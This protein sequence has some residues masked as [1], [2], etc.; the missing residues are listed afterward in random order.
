MRSELDEL[1][2]TCE[3][4]EHVIDALNAAVCTLARRAKALKAENADL[5]ARTERRSPAGERIEARFALDVHAPGAARSVVA[6]C[7]GERVEPGVLDNAL[8]LATELV[9]NSVRHSGMP[10][11]AGVVVGVT[12][13]PDSVRIDVDDPGCSGAIAPRPPD[14][15]SGGFGL[16]LVQTLSERWGVERAVEGGTRVWVQ[17]VCAPASRGQPARHSRRAAQW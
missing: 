4:Q 11:S 2:A 13:R 10:A 12:L 3:R 16:N 6:E 17:L 8:L 1:Q 15:E 5:R 9:S 7:L 14:P